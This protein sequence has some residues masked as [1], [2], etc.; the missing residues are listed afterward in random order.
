MRHR[1]QS[2]VLPPVCVY[3]SPS[4]VQP[5]LAAV[6]SPSGRSGALPPRRGDSHDHVNILESLTGSQATPA[7]SM[8][9]RAPASVRTFAAMPTPAPDPTTQ[10]SNSS[11]PRITCM[12]PPPNRHI[13]NDG[14]DVN[15]GNAGNNG[16]NG[17]WMIGSHRRPPLS[18]LSSLPSLPSLDSAEQRD[19]LAVQ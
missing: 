5:P 13:V 19:E 2:N 6:N 9:T 1:N 8:T 7:S 18:S 15:D 11:R 4:M 16:N 10:T 17:R 12:C 14:N 3:G